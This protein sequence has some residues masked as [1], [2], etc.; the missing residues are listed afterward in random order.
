MALA[1]WYVGMEDKRKL[2][3]NPDKYNAMGEFIFY[4]DVHVLLCF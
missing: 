2:T 3:E 4:N 1:F